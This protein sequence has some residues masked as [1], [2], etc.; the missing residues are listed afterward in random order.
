MMTTNLCRD[1]GLRFL[2]APC[3]GVADGFCVCTE[4][5]LIIAAHGRTRKPDAQNAARAGLVLD[6]GFNIA[7]FR[8]SAASDNPTYPVRRERIYEG[9]REAGVT[10][11][12][13]NQNLKS[14]TG[15]L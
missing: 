4:R 5:P 13:S 14:G 7:R 9:M 2:T 6:P 1:Y 10:E 15:H 11:D 3:A 12:K 8:A